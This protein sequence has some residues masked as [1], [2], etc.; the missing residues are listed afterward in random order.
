MAP[1]AGKILASER[2]STQ[3]SSEFGPAGQ[4]PTLRVHKRSAAVLDIKDAIN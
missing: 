3:S 2:Y 4:D 1:G